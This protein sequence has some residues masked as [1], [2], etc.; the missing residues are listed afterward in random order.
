MRSN[1]KT[2]MAKIKTDLSS[3][4]A[5]ISREIKGL[6]PEVKEIGLEEKM[7]I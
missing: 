2:V 3:K 4:T 7:S 5:V 1:R 6:Q